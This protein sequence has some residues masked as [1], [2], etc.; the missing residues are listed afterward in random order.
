MACILHILTL[1]LFICICSPLSESIHFNF[2]AVFNFGDSNSDT[3]ELIASGIES[4]N[5]PYGQSY[6]HKP[7]GRYCDGRLIIDFLSN[8]FLSH[9]VICLFF[10]FFISTLFSLSVFPLSSVFK[11][12]VSWFIF[13]TNCCS[14]CNGQAISKR[15]SG[16]SWLAKFP[17]RVQFCSCRV[18]YTSSNT[19]ICQP[20]LIWAPGGSVSQIQSSGSRIAISKYVHGSSYLSFNLRKFIDEIIFLILFQLRN[21]KST[22]QQKIILVRRF[23]C[24]I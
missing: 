10:L 5:P 21:L 3:G 23:T 6:F 24:L 7:S 2:P 1:V 13:Y 12:T 4:I 9:Q 18:H 15:L 20:I 14:G 19:N 8:F 17:K 11:D 16:F 22:S